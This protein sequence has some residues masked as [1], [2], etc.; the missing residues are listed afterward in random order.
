M[1]SQLCGAVELD[2]RTSGREPVSEKHVL[3]C[4][5][6]LSRQGLAVLTAS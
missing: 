1:L 6:R 2:E 3:C 5:E 4:I